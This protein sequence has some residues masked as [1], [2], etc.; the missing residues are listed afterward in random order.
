MSS[1]RR[2]L[3]TGEPILFAP[4]RAGRP[5]AFD[6]Q[7]GMSGPH[8]VGQTFLSAECPFCPG[9]ESMTPPE[10]ARTGDPWRVR[11]FPNKYPFAPHHEVIVDTRDHKATFDQIDGAEVIGVYLDRYR[12]LASRNGVKSVVLFKNH[13]PAA[14]ASLRHP[15]SQIAAVTFVP[16]RIASES[17]AFARAISCPLCDALATHRVAELIIRETPTMVLLAPHGSSFAYQQWIVSKRHCSDLT[18][19]D[20]HELRDTATLLQSASVTMR[21][22]AAAHNWLFLGFPGVAAAHCYV[23]LFPRTTNIAGFELATGTFI[24]VVDPCQTVR[25]SHDPAS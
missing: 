9:N 25:V 21:Q 6:G 24:D 7:T 12:A 18:A 14:G 11:V 19:L 2:N 13:G 20:D 17:H 1:I 10:I 8:S 16:P 23:D 3:I 22:I 15:H 5:N 4:D